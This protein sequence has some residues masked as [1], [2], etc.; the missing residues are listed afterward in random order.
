MDSSKLIKSFDDLSLENHLPYPI[1]RRARSSSPVKNRRPLPLTD[2]NFFDMRIP[3]V[4]FA[5]LDD[6]HLLA[7]NNS[8][9]S[10]SQ[11]Q[12][13]S[14]SNSPISKRLHINSHSK[15][16]V[17][18]IPFT[19]QLP[20]KLSPK[21]KPIASSTVATPQGSPT[22]SRSG[23]SKSLGATPNNQN[24]ISKGSRLVY[25]GNGYEKIDLSDE[26]DLE[27][28]DFPPIQNANRKPPPVTK[29]KRKSSKLNI[30]KQFMSHDEL[31]IIEEASNSGSSRASSIKSKLEK[32][33]PPDPSL[34]KNSHLISKSLN[35][36]NINISKINLPTDESFVKE[37]PRLNVESH[38]PPHCYPSGNL[39]LS[40]QPNI[41]QPISNQLKKLSLQLSQEQEEQQQQR[42]NKQKHVKPASPPRP[43]NVNFIAPLP[44]R[45]DTEKTHEAHPLILNPNIT[46]SKVPR[47]T[48]NLLSKSDLPNNL[49]MNQRFPPNQ[50]K[51]NHAIQYGQI[52]NQ[53]KDNVLKIYKRSF[54]DES[55]V[56][57]VSSFSSVGDFMNFSNNPSLRST[58]NINTNIPMVSTT[59]TNIESPSVKNTDKT[60]QEK[61]KIEELNRNN[62]KASAK[63]TL[64]SSTE[65]SWN[66]LQ[67]SID[68]SIED[69]LNSPATG[70]FDFASKINSK[71]LPPLP[72]LNT[73]IEKVETAPLRISR[74]ATRE[75]SREVSPAKSRKN[76]P[77]PPPLQDEIEQSLAKLSNKSKSLNEKSN[78]PPFKEKDNNGA[79]KRFSFPNNSQNITNSREMRSRQLSSNSMKSH[80]SRFSHMSQSTGQIEIPDLSNKS[81]A[82]SYSTRR[83]TS[84]FNG[85][86]FDDLP[87]ESGFSSETSASIGSQMSNGKL[88]PIGVPTRAS[89]EIIKEQFK[90]MHGDDVTDSDSDDIFI[91]AMKSKSSPNIKQ[92]NEAF[93]KDPIDYSNR[94]ILEPPSQVNEKGNRPRSSS[95]S[96]VRHRRNKSMYGIDFQNNDLPV[97]PTRIHSRSKSTSLVKS[98]PG[99]QKQTRK[100]SSKEQIKDLPS[101]MDIVINEPPRPVSYEVDFIEAKS[102]VDDFPDN[103]SNTPTVNEIYKTPNVTFENLPNSKDISN[104]INRQKQLKAKPNQIQFKGLK[105]KSGSVYSKSSSQS[106]NSEV[107]S[108]T[109]D[110]TEENVDVCMIQRNDSKLSYRSITEKKDGKDVEVVLVEENE[111]ENSSRDDLSSIY[112]KYQTDWVSRSNSML[113][114]SSSGSYASAASFESGVSSEAQ[115]QLKERPNTIEIYKQMQAIRGMG[116]SP[117]ENLSQAR[118]GQS[119]NSH[120]S[121]RSNNSVNYHSKRIQPPKPTK[122]VN[123]TN[124][125]SQPNLYS[126]LNIFNSPQNSRESNYFD[127]TTS[128]NY[129]F[130]TFMKQRAVSKPT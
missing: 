23:G 12:I 52:P 109:I 24:K 13:K 49:I 50:N 32:E 55:H 102:Q 91:P 101:N 22:P 54:S 26:E 123:F 18:P 115:L 64:S 128:E 16:Y 31:S 108:I 122:N 53:S 9:V 130:N 119:I 104:E 121:G 42:K 68:I 11:L 79:G 4:P 46:K 84:S 87:S 94:R 69:S 85:T 71:E 98:K 57:S 41:K 7:T 78:T 3:S 47:P 77:T 72:E 44:H 83:S 8:G 33:L 56:S 126:N 111:S 2:P 35:T 36:A 37:V 88:E 113:S 73:E 82:D 103:V 21:N 110:L 112:S 27:I 120:T 67:K 45:N 59:I 125:K 100:Q 127:Y 28:D 76:R 106:T 65:S 89:Q 93:D 60:S 43:V 80:R 14:L 107:D 124:S 96:P 39:S 74:N 40:S 105:K 62:S 86:T 118:K 90:M 70:E 99:I 92:L 38:H 34:N 114:T 30:Q 117:I 81:V 116:R 17:I 58:K 25:T 6:I 29:N 129:D 75:P 20:P 95:S 15:D 61:P 10:F 66:S 48:A 51:A 97:S 5:S 1:E 63:S 19:L